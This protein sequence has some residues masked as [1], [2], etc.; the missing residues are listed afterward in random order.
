MTKTSNGKARK[1]FEFYYHYPTKWNRSVYRTYNAASNRLYPVRPIVFGASLTAATAY[2]LKNPENA[3]IKALPKFGH[4]CIRIGAASILTAYT[5]VFL[6]RCFLKYWFFTYKDWLFESPKKPSL[7]TKVWVIVQK[8]LEYVCPPQLHSND[9]LLPNVPVPNLEDTVA[10]YLESIEPLTDKEEFAEIKTKSEVFLKNEGPKLQRYA[11][12]M[13]YFSD[14]YVTGFWEKY[15]YLYGKNCLLVNS[16]VSPVGTFKE[17]PSGQATKAAYIVYIEALSMLAYDREGMKPPGKGLV[18]TRHYDNCYAVTR[19]PGEQVDEQ[20]HYGV[21]RHVAVYSN[22]CYYKVDAFDEN[23]KLYTLEQLTETFK[24]LIARDDIPSEGEIQLAALTTDRRDQWSRN[25]KEFFLSNEVN[26]KA[27]ELIESAAYFLVLDDADNWGYDPERPE[28]LENYLRSM[29][30]GNGGN[31]WAD[32]SL[33]YMV[34]KNGETGAVGEHSVA[35]GAEFDHIQENFIYMNHSYLKYPD[36]DSTP[37]TSGITF[38]KAERLNFDISDKMRS[39]INRCVEEYSLLRDDVDLAATV[40]TDFGKGRIKEGKCSPDAFLQMAIQLAN[41]RDQG[42]FHLTYESGS[43]RFFAN[44]RTET[45][46]T[47]SKDSCAFVRAMEDPESSAAERLTLLR[48]ACCSHTQRNRECM[49][50]R[51]VDRHLFVLYILSK[52]TNTSSPF[53]DY[54]ISQP[55]MLSTSQPPVMTDLNDED[56]DKN[57]SWLGACFGPVTKKGYERS[58]SMTNCTNGNEETCTTDNSSLGYVRVCCFKR[59]VTRVTSG[60]A[61]LV[62]ITGL[63]SVRLLF[64]NDLDT[65]L[66]IFIGVGNAFCSILAIMALIGLCRRKPTLLIPLVVIMFAFCILVSVLLVVG[67]VCFVIDQNKHSH[68]SVKES[69]SKY[70]SVIVGCACTLPLLIWGYCVFVFISPLF[71]E[72]NTTSTT[73]AGQEENEFKYVSCCCCRIRVK[74]ATLFIAVFTLLGGLYN[75]GSLPDKDITLNYKIFLAVTNSVW[76]FS[77]FLAAVGVYKRNPYV[78]VPFM[79]MLIIGCITLSIALISSVF[80]QLLLIE[81]NKEPPLDW[82]SLIIVTAIS[83]PFTVWFTIVTRRC[84]Q[85]LKSRYVNHM[86]LNEI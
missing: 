20:V 62:I 30:T 9:N 68:Q 78:L 16:S 32:K 7:Q 67:V 46:R 23:G 66:K 10:R 51:G 29:L 1:P 28:V 38:G 48:K 84:H 85:Y 75:I 26:K 54:Y 17:I 79:V 57:R 37:S 76:C 4:Y 53:L 43:Q 27:L 60:I 81:T 22:G 71:F 42:R 63:Q 69:E 44:S 65:S 74:R 3:L 45:I 31:R 55:W 77:A 24:E 36:V 72:I 35:D 50:G 80:F 34:S 83:L 5:P 6:M 14:N 41:Y 13:S 47:V 11:K 59:D 39:E 82:G 56:E 58:A 52:G 15:A 86:E 49:V 64:K 73:M 25:R 18:S 61:G 21:S 33:N 2:H 19:V 70:I 40:F 12:L 8:L